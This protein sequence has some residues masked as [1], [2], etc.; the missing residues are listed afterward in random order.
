[1]GVNVQSF[2]YKNE[3][4][5]PNARH[6]FL[7]QF[8]FPVVSSLFLL[9]KKFTLQLKTLYSPWTFFQIEFNQFLVFYPAIFSNT[10][11]VLSF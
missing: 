6:F 1:M 2:L 8:Q 5:E 7:A 4:T 10:Q 3:T 11:S 9:L